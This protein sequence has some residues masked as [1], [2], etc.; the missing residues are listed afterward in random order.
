MPRTYVR[1]LALILPFVLFSC[2]DPYPLGDITGDKQLLVVDGMITNQG[3]PYKV[4]LRYTSASLKSYEGDKVTEA[5][6]SITDDLGHEV[7]LY[8]NE[9]GEYVSDAAAPQGEAASTYQLHIALPDGRR[10]VSQPEQ[11]PA[12]VPIDS[13]YAQ[14][15]RRTFL[16][17]FDQSEQEEWGMQIYLNTGTQTNRAGF[18]RWNWED[19]YQIATPLSLPF[20]SGNPVCWI[21]SRQLHYLNIASTLGFSGDVVNRRPILFVS[22]KTKKLVLKYAVLVKQYS[23][24]RSAY[25]YWE[26]VE[27]Q[28]E[29]TGSVFAPQP[30]QLLGNLYSETDSE[31]V[32]LGYFQVCSVTE[33][34][35]F[36]ER[37]D[38]P[39]EGG[40]I[41]DGDAECNS[42]DPPVYCYDCALWPGAKTVPPIYWK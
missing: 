4:S 19:V 14:L 32:V 31:E 22:K 24:T 37:K 15:K 36:I 21:T 6:V 1:Y 13:I 12:A 23:L 42:D 41:G 7:A 39:S 3:G 18:Y 11:M 29:N 8:P 33:K 16:S 5:T 35:F 38:V 30:A 26:K 2:I 34:V 10:Y 28:Q 20:G 25:D 27:A 40:P 9:S 17:G